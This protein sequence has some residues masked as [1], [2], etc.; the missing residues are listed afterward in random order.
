LRFGKTSWTSHQL[1]ARPVP[2]ENR[3]T[4][5]TRANIHALSGFRTSDSSARAIEPHSPRRRCHEHF[6]S[7]AQTFALLT[8]PVNISH[9][10]TFWEPGSSVGI[11][12]GYGLDDRPIEVRSAAG[13]KD[14][15]SNYWSG[16]HP[17]SCTTIT[18]G[19]FPGAKARPGR[20]IDHSPTSI[21][22]VVNE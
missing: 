11:V 17:A 10:I 15:F 18:G 14:L 4:K 3:I 21:A 2:P 20:D 12:S 16:A 22:E 7:V 13:A 1:F 8:P 6:N 5:K 19:R 9:Y